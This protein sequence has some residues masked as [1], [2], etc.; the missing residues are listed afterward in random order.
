MRAKVYHEHVVRGPSAGPRDVV[1][2]VLHP[3][4]VLEVAASV[5]R[6]FAEVSATTELVSDLVV[7]QV[8]E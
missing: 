5:G 6:S 8:T 4:G 3:L 7:V 2:T 1:G